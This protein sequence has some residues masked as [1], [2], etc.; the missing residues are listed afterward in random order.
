[1][2]VNKEKG[3][4]EILQKT[5][6]SLSNDQEHNW[7]KKKTRKKRVWPLQLKLSIR[8]II[9]KNELNFEG[10]SKARWSFIHLQQLL[11]QRERGN[12]NHFGCLLNKKP[13]I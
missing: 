2:N 11:T 9:N 13:G 6:V 8:L 10:S 5:A 3:K 1:M 4:G 12:T 7:R